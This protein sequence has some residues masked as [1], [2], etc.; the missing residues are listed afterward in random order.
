MPIA[1]TRARWTASPRRAGTGARPSRT[2]IL[3]SGTAGSARGARGLEPLVERA[4]GAQHR[5]LALRPGREERHARA[6]DVLERGDG[7][8]RAARVRP[9]EADPRRVS[10]PAG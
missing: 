2:S 7:L 3:T 8:P 4:A 10:P 5:L 6:D 9:E 1:S